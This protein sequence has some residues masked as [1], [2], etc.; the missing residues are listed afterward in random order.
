MT[1]T[2]II[3]IFV[4]LCSASICHAQTYEQLIEHGLAAAAADSLEAAEACF[5]EALRKSPNDYRNSLVFT[6]LGR[7]QEAR[8]WQNPADK[9]LADSALESYTVALSLTPEAV[10]MLEARGD[11]LL[12][13][14]LYER[15]VRDF[16]AALDFA[17]KNKDI[18][19]HRAYS[20]FQIRLYGESRADYDKVLE[21]D[22]TNYAALLGLAL[23]CQQTDHK[24]EAI[25][26]MNHLVE[27]YPDSTE[28]YAVRADIYMESRQEDL[29]LLDLNHAISLEADN[30]RYI[31]ARAYLHKQMGNKRLALSDFNRAIELGI[32]ESSLRNDMK[33]CR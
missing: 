5:K 13:L 20:Y 10:P 2:R 29:A 6:N 1:I 24:T 18:R 30:P 28:L 7:V 8:Y 26:R 32:P 19:L 11:F 31:L 12:K 14:Q 23:I 3:L 15:A 25:E 16:S 22:A 9:K 27:L 4:F 33:A 21:S 17:P